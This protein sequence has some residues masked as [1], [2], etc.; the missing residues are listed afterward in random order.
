VEEEVGLGGAVHLQKASLQG[1]I[2]VNLDSEEEGV[3]IVGCA[4][5][6]AAQIHLPLSFEP[7]GNGA[8]FAVAVRGLNGG[9]SGVDIHK[10][11]ASANRLLASLLG[12]IQGK[13]P[14]RIVDLKGGTAHNA[15]AREAQAVLMAA[16]E[17]APRLGEIV[18]AFQQTVQ[19]EYATTEPSLAIQI[20]PTQAE[21]VLT[22]RDTQKAIDLLQALP[23]GVVDMSASVAGF[24]ETSNNL[25][26]VQIQ[27][28]E[29]V[30][31]SSQRS[32]V[33]SR[34]DEITRRV[35]AIGRLAGARVEIAEGYPAWQ[36]EMHSPLLARAR[37]VYQ[38]I[39]G[40]SPRVEMIHAGLECGIIGGIFGDM[41]MLSLGAT[42]LD[43]HSPNERLYLPSLQKAW[44]FL[45]ALLQSYRE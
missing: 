42:I 39:F 31:H 27:G 33:M 15:I 20:I 21:R 12:E 2:L 38:A 44:D 4:G 16:A 17:D 30:I 24:V 19:E 23:H 9:H 29:L 32:T 1:R 43:P 13:V 36:P 41:D 7:A 3:F 8:A 37:Q 28:D 14:F 45:V 11:R 18:Q 6:R 22:E 10:H 40:R 34:L 35:A 25:A 5:G 26:L